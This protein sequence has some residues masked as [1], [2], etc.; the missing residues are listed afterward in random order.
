MWIDLTGGDGH[1]YA[2]NNDQREWDQQRGFT[3]DGR[4][5]GAVYSSLSVSSSMGAFRTGVDESSLVPEDERRS[6]SISFIQ[7]S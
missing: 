6:F 7:Y 3:A 4:G 2:T 1:I 5:G